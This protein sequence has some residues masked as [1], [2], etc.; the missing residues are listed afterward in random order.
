MR[1]PC[2]K[3]PKTGAVRC[4]NTVM[5]RTG[6]VKLATQK[7]LQFSQELGEIH[8]SAALSSPENRRVMTSRRNFP[9]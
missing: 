4:H 8:Y 5:M 6:L 1:T 3:S 9:V 2:A 7:Y